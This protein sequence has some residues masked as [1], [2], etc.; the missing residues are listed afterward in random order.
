M[1]HT[2]K[3]IRFSATSKIGII[4]AI[5]AVSFFVGTLLRSSSDAH[6][7]LRASAQNVKSTSIGPVS[8]SDERRAEVA[9]LASRLHSAVDFEALLDQLKDWAKESPLSA[10][11][12]AKTIQPNNLSLQAISA[13]LLEWARAEP[14][15]AWTWARENSVNDC[16]ALLHSIGREE[17]KLAWNFANEYVA[18]YPS[19]RFRSY[20]RLFEGIA[21]G[22]DYRLAMELLEQSDIAPDRDA[23]DGKYTFVQTIMDQWTAFSPSEVADYLK[24][25]PDPYNSP[26]VSLA[27]SLLIPRWASE[28]PLA[29]L[30]YGLALPYESVKA[31]KAAFEYG[32]E[33]LARRD[34]TE[35][36]EWLNNNDQGPE[37][38][39][40]IAYLATNELL[41]EYGPEFAKQWADAI[42][43][44]QI[45]D[46]SLV[47]IAVNHLISDPG[48]ATELYAAE[49]YLSDEDWGRAL[50]IAQER[51]RP[52]E[53][54]A[55]VEDYPV[56]LDGTE[57]DGY[58]DKKPD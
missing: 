11:A 40:S 32:I 12:F 13:I 25:L 51:L 53:T 39:W 55:E 4:L 56:P 27:H 30:E 34:L 36:S 38:D 47:E 14:E 16:V 19:D 9:K 18:D 17:P 52:Q 50:A 26:R 31:R 42:Q 10:L 54:F 41:T 2:I 5:S 29:A 6:A 1:I 49:N 21:Y 28:D 44:V 48:A 43:N 46:E 58:Y 23:K 3:S 45:R 8:R 35:A 15:S 37:F 22:G 33:E 24:S 57:V 7:S 20:D